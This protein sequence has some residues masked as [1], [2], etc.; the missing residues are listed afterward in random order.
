LV[1]VESVQPETGDVGGVD[2]LVGGVGV[3]IGGVEVDVGGVDVPVF[4]G[5]EVPVGGV[6]CGELVEAVP[7]PLLLLPPLP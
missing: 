5:V 3:D 4:G 2:V 7:P 6:A 1:A